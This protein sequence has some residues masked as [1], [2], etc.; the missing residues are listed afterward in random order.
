MTNPRVLRVAATR[1]LN[2][3]RKAWRKARKEHDERTV[4]DAMRAC[5]LAGRML[6]RAASAVPSEAA[7]MRLEAERLDSAAAKLRTELVAILEPVTAL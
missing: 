7:A 6:R 3:A 5:L 1:A 2:D 4:R